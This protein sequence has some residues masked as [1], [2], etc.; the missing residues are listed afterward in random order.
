MAKEQPM[1]CLY[2]GGPHFDRYCPR[3]RKFTFDPLTHLVSSVEFFRP[4][5]VPTFFQKFH[6]EGSTKDPTFSDEQR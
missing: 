1:E 2:C 5:D 4:D 6:I 3:V